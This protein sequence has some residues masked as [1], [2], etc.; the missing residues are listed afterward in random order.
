VLLLPG[1][2]LVSRPATIFLFRNFA[3]R[4][5]PE[6]CVRNQR[7]APSPQVHPAISVENENAWKNFTDSKS[8]H[9]DL[10]REQKS[11]VQNVCG[12]VYAMFEKNYAVTGG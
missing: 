7:S 10:I 3:H 2:R 5:S 1:N 12:I 11:T 9:A 6:L 4:I 8:H